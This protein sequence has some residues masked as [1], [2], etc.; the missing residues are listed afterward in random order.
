MKNAFIQV[1]NLRDVLFVDKSNRMRSAGF[2]DSF[3]IRTSRGVGPF[4]NFSNLAR[5][6]LA[7]AE[8]SPGF[9]VFILP[10]AG[11]D[12]LDKKALRESLGKLLAE[13]FLTVQRT[14]TGESP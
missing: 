11:S 14:L 9:F 7:R 13:E 2:S 6:L 10:V 3:L 4:S 8:S 1:N 5:E 12:E